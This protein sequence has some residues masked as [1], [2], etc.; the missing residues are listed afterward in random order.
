MIYCPYCKKPTVHRECFDT[1]TQ[2]TYYRCDICGE[3]NDGDNA[4]EANDAVNHPSHYTQGGI[5][6]IDGIRASMTPEGFAAY[7][8]GNTLK[9]IWRYKN[10]NGLEDLKK[11]KVYLD[12]LIETETKI[13][14][15]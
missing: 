4:P 2:E 7:C 3:I 5:E 12:W 11:A 8:K 15:K 1:F 13:N 6:C 14:N 10:K 9:Y